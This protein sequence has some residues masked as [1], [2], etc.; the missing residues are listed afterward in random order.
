MATKKA[1]TSTI[2]SSVQIMFDCGHLLTVSITLPKTTG[3][4][5]GENNFCPTCNCEQDICAVS[6]AHIDGYTKDAED[7]VITDAV[8]TNTPEADTEFCVVEDN[9]GGLHLFIFQD[10][11]PSYY[12][13]GFGFNP[14]QILDCIKSLAAGADIR[15]WDSNAE[16]IL[17]LFEVNYGTELS[18]AEVIQRFWQEVSAEEVGFKIVADGFTGKWVIYP[19]LMGEAAKQEFWRD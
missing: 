13:N 6:H 16:E 1:S 4:G 5:L 19:K 10:N 11:T 9:S 3:D 7:E 14:S 17:Q 2:V 12:Q 15:D 18:Y 8:S